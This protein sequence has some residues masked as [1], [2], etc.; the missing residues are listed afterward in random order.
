M[1]L[2]FCDIITHCK[3]VRDIESKLF[4]EYVL[5]KYFDEKN[6][7]MTIKEAL[8]FLDSGDVDIIL[9]IVKSVE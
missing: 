8:P 9:P 1:N 7:L 2:T 3:K 6:I 4:L 5:F